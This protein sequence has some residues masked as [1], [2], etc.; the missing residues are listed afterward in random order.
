[1]EYASIFL[2]LLAWSIC[3]RNGAFSQNDKS[4]LSFYPS[5]YL[6]LRTAVRLIVID[7]VTE[8]TVRRI[9]TLFYRGYQYIFWKN[10]LEALNR[11]S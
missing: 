10:E 1:M 8:L 7:S 4:L 6:R 11:T 9:L 2:A 5:I 3:R